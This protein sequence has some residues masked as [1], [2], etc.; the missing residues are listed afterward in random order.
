[1]DKQF[2]TWKEQLGQKRRAGMIAATAASTATLVHCHL[3]VALA[4]VLLLDRS[5]SEIISAKSARKLNL[6]LSNFSKIFDLPTSRDHLCSPAEELAR[7]YAQACVDSLLAQTGT[8]IRG[9]ALHQRQIGRS[10]SPLSRYRRP[11]RS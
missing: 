11:V 7:Q 5:C 2:C 9:I 8:A 3:P 4:L 6:F 10:C 1:M